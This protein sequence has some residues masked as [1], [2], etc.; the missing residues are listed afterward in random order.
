MS[1]FRRIFGKSDDDDGPDDKQKTIETPAAIPANPATNNNDAP[2]E[3]SENT[4]QDEIDPT[5]QPVAIDQIQAQRNIADSVT[6]PLHTDQRT[7]SFD[8]DTLTTNEN[9][10]FGQT[11]DVG[12]V[13]S[14]NQDSMLSV[15]I[16]SRSVEEHPDFGLFIVADGM[17]G[18]HDGEKASAIVVRVL[19]TEIMNTIYMPILTGDEDAMPIT[20]ALVSALHNANRQVIAHVPEG[21]TTATAVLVI[22]NLAHLVHVGDSR[23][24]IVTHDNIEQITRDHSLVQRLIELNQLTREEADHHPQ[25]NVLYRAIGQND[26]LEVDTSTRRLPENSRLL[27]C[28]DGLWGLIEENEIREI[29]MSA[30]NPQT[31]S[32]K[33]ISLANARGGTDNIT[34]IIVKVSG[35]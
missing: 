18:H 20:E 32:D 15:L 35:N 4:L 1:L 21:G 29:I 14:N 9:L 26:Q 11:S 30:P 5:T 17:G 6:R 24:Y 19:T 23:A 12:R 10:S 34:A 16:A 3:S 2:P 7:L 22:G 25:K 27:L 13:R 8:P 28:S 31:A 33:L